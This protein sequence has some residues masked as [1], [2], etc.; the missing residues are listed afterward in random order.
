M[1][2][3]PPLLLGITACCCSPSASPSESNGATAKASEGG[4]APHD[5]AVPGGRADFIRAAEEDDWARPPPDWPA[6]EAERP[7]T[8][9]VERYRAEAIRRLRRD[10]AAGLTRDES[11][12]LTGS[13]EAHA[14]AAF[15]L[16]GFATNYSVTRLMVSGTVVIVESNS[17]G[18]L[19]DL[20]RHPCVAFLDRRPSQVYTYATY[21]E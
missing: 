16:R 18:G 13:Q 3:L 5:P 12:R 15:L 2:W 14:G 8:R 10:S 7:C 19:H 17:L 6:D 21:D 1:R 4:P 11:R 9:V 20:R